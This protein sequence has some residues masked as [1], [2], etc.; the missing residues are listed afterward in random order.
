MMDVIKNARGGAAAQ[1]LDAAPLVPPGLPS[2]L[3]ERR[4]DIRQAEQVLAAANAQ[5]GVAKA[6]YFP[7]IGLT[8]VLG[9]E[10]RDL[11]ELLTAPART[12][13][14]GAAA[15]A[16][17]FNAGRTRAN[18]RFSESVERELVVSYQR[19]IYRALREVSDALAGYHKT[20]EQRVQQVQLVADLRDAAQR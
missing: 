20:G 15:V 17:I 1:T 7:R 11:A 10:S 6:D 14:V 19:T 5:I 12:W 8:G 18:V 2:S 4:P 13:S 16:P 3:L 9:V